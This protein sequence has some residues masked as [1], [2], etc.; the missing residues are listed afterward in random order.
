MLIRRIHSISFLKPSA[1]PCC[2]IGWLT[3]T[4]RVKL[5]R[6][7]QHHLIGIFLSV[8]IL[9]PLF[10]WLFAIILW[11]PLLL[12]TCPLMLATSS[13]WMILTYGRNLSRTIPVIW[14]F[15]SS[16]A[17]VFGSFL[18]PLRPGSVIDLSLSHPVCR[19]EQWLS[20]IS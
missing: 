19:H 20:R 11:H 5:T 1:L 13:I 12:S 7:V 15:V 9:L 4:R 17:S 2:V 3:R 10:V 14:P 18:A 8:M 16:L 6:L